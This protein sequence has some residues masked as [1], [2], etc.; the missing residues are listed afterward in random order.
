MNLNKMEKQ[1]E[2]DAKE[3]IGNGE[4][5]YYNVVLTYGND[6]DFHFIPTEVYMEYGEFDIV[7]QKRGDV[8]KRVT[9]KQSPPDGTAAATN[10]LNSSSAKS[11]SLVAHQNGFKDMHGFF[12]NI[13]K[14]RKDGKYNSARISKIKER[15]VK[16]KYYI[17]DSKVLNL[18]MTNLTTL[19][20][21]TNIITN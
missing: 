13:S 4:V 7:K 16:N 20:R 21:D 9:F 6:G 2:S 8:H 18:H 14:G 15:M 5:L 12:V 1:V 3:R 11:L 10:N 19:L 17:K